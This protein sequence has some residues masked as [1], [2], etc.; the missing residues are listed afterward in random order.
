MSIWQ[1]GA[2][3]FLL[4][5]TAVLLKN[6]GWRASA[7]FSAFALVLLLSMQTED[8]LSLG[9]ALSDVPF[10]A[11]LEEA[12][13]AVLKIVGVGILTGLSADICRELGE[14]GIAKGV[15]IAGRLE[16]LA[17]SMPYFQKIIALGVELLK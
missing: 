1:V 9:G 6:L 15:C 8:F 13:V 7:V 17:I 14:G 5:V 12:T 16:I 11:E 3:G 2:M 10:G 4:A